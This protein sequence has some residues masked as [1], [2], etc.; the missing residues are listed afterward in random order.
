ME[1]H[2][3][4]ATKKGGKRKDGKN[5]ASVSRRGQKGFRVWDLGSDKD[6]V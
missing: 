6:L 4:S 2:M 5:L 1:M 3:E